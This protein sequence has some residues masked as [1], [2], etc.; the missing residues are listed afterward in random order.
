MSGSEWKERC[1]FQA[2]ST[3]KLGGKSFFAELFG[4]KIKNFGTVSQETIRTTDQLNSRLNYSLE[5]GLHAEV[6]DRAICQARDSKKE[7]KINSEKVSDQKTIET[8]NFCEKPSGV[9]FKM[10]TN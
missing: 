1:S 2:G 9:G 3:N 8:E 7:K 5:Q 10:K 4:R 6:C